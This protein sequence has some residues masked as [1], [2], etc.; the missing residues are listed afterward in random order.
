MAWALCAASLLFVLALCAMQVALAAFL[1]TWIAPLFAMIFLLVGLIAS[2]AS[3]M[4]PLGL[5]L[6]YTAAGYCIG[7][8]HLPECSP[9]V[10]APLA[11]VFALAALLF[12]LRLIVLAVRRLHDAGASATWVMALF[13]LL[14]GALLF[15]AIEIAT[16]GGITVAVEALWAV[17]LILVSVHMGLLL[18]PGLRL[19]ATPCESG[20]DKSE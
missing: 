7:S 3:P 14:Y 17:F 12:C 2:A 18:R 1:P 10:G 4:V 16:E 5:V 9:A 11:I 8:A 20:E 15:G 13:G 19:P 6:G